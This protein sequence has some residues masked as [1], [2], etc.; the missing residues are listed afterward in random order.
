MLEETCKKLNNLN[1]IEITFD[2]IYTTETLTGDTIMDWITFDEDNA[3]AGYTVDEDKAMAYVEDL[4]D[5]YD[6]FGKDRE[7]KTTKRGTITI[8]EGQ[9]CYGWWID[10]QRPATLSWTLLKRASLPKLSLSTM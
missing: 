1:D 2:F 3:E 5:K 4:A 6:T 10:Q 8:S 9:G 7:F